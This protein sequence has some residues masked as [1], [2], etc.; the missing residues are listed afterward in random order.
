[1]TIDDEDDG[2]DKGDGDCGCGSC[3]EGCPYLWPSFLT[4]LVVGL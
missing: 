4:A 3:G 1:M 2:D